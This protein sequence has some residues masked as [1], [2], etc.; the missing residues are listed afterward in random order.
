MLYRPACKRLEMNTAQL[1][2]DCSGFRRP[3]LDGQMSLL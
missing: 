1:E 2:L 3:N